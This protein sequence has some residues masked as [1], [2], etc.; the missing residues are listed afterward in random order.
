MWLDGV[1]WLPLILLALE[2]VLDGK[3]AGPFIAAL[4]VCFLSTWYISYM[5]GIFCCVYLTVRLVTLTPSCG[6]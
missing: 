5:I 4:T 6:R 3:G 1:I 2:R